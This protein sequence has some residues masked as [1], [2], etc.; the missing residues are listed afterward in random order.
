MDLSTIMYVRYVVSVKSEMVAYHKVLDMM[1]KMLLDLKGIRPDEYY[2]GQ[3][4]LKDFNENAM[5]LRIPNSI[6]K[7]R[8]R[9]G[10][11]E[12]IRRL[13]G[14]PMNYL[15]EY[16]KRNVSESGF[17]SDKTATEGFIY[18]RRKYRK[19]MPGFCKGVIYD[20]MPPHD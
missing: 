12:T 17:S 18:Q 4:I 10:W 6:S 14:D 16:F 19:E 5:I 20:S 3:S 15:K 1:D 13:I 7:I 11:M 2:S 8:V 9:G